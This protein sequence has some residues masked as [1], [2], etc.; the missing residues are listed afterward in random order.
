MMVYRAKRRHGTQ[1]G[2][3][4]MGAAAILLLIVLVSCDTPLDVI[5]DSDRATN[6][7]A[8]DG[9]FGDRI[10]ITW[11][12]PDLSESTEDEDE[13]EEVTINGYDILRASPSGGETILNGN[14]VDAG[15]TSYVD[16][17]LALQQ[18]VPYEYRVRVIFSNGDVGVSLADTG[19]AISARDIPVGSRLRLY[20][21]DYDTATA[22]SSAN[23]K[24][25]FQ[26]PV[27]AG[28]RYE[29]ET[30]PGDSSPATEVRLLSERKLEPAPKESS[31]AG[32]IFTAIRGGLHYVEL[33]GGTG[34]IS[35]R[36]LGAE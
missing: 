26:F 20:E 11:T 30:V 27:Q 3:V 9:E 21:R 22:L 7:S 10:E 12:A 6:V 19:Y 32:S 13:D 4:R 17:G 1:S 18:G 5:T 14:L 34:T 28:W 16:S 35:I 23:G 36:Y 24:V 15:A 8:T 29:I 31:D 25:W 2:M 33:S